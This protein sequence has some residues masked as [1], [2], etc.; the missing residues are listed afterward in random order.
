MSKIWI[1]A[2][3]NLALLPAFLFVFVY[4]GM[5]HCYWI[6]NGWCADVTPLLVGVLSVIAATVCY[7]LVFAIRRIGK[8]TTPIW[9]LSLPLLL[10]VFLAGMFFRE[11]ERRRA[12]VWQAIYEK[13]MEG[14][15]AGIGFWVGPNTTGLM[16]QQ[17]ILN[18]SIQQDFTEGA[19][20]LLE[21]GA[22]PNGRVGNCHLYHPHLTTHVKNNEELHKILKPLSPPL[23]PQYKAIWI[24]D[25]QCGSIGCD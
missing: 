1:Q 8:L 16:N 13:N 10:A 11:S 4:T 18:W 12:A 6:N 22:D 14:L 2:P 7:V 24:R 25:G 21:K 9:K 17:S 19:K 23:C 20:F 3:I 5:G 15:R